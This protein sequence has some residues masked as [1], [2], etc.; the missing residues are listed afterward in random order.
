MSFPLG[1]C[2]GIAVRNPVFLPWTLSSPPRAVFLQ[3]DVVM[4]FF[5]P[6][7][8]STTIKG[9]PLDLLSE[10]HIGLLAPP[11]GFTFESFSHRALYG[12]L[13]RLLSRHLPLLFH[14]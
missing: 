9:L 13:I 8:H 2:G 5:C 10:C 4:I 14:T 11:L 12:E 7:C 3:T 6:P 1:R